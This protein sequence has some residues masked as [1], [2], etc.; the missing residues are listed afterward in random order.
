MNIVIGT[1]GL[2]LLCLVAVFLT[3]SRPVLANEAVAKIRK[4]SAILL[5]L[6]I[7]H[8]AE[9]YVYQFFI[10][11][12]AMLGL[13]PWPEEFFA[14]FNILWIMVWAL[15][16][17]GIRLYPRISIFPLWFL[18]IASVAN[19]LFHP[20]ISITQA[21]YFPGLMSSVF[22]GIV[23]VLLLQRLFRATKTAE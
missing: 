21:E 5:S 11:F 16:I 19:G 2:F 1:S 17:L 9:E 14:L 6:H 20:L 10:Q 4:L 13:E 7:I 18:A 22:V 8:F 3:L 12:P 15:A 23:G